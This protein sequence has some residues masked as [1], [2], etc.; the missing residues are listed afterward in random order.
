MD[1]TTQFQASIPPSSP[2]SLSPR[3]RTPPA[4]TTTTT[5]NATPERT[6]PSISL[7]S[8]QPA[9]N[10]DSIDDPR[11]LGNDFDDTALSLPN[12]TAIEEEMQRRLMDVESSF[13]PE[14]STIEVGG[15]AA[16]RDD[17][18]LVGVQTPEESRLDGQD[19]ASRP[20]ALA[21]GFTTPV[22]DR[23]LEPES[24]LMDDSKGGRRDGSIL[25]AI[26]AS[27]VINTSSL[28]TMSSSP[29]AEEAARTVSK[30]LSST[31]RSDNWPPLE[32]P[33]FEF[34]NAEPSSELDLEGSSRQ[35]YPR[36]RSASPLPTLD[37]GDGDGDT[38]NNES[39]SH[40][41]T[42]S[43]SDRRR[44][45]PKFLV[46][47]QSAQRVSMSSVTSAATDA[48]SDANMGVDYALQSGGAM[49]TSSEKR[50][51]AHKQPKAGLSRSISLGSMASVMSALSD[52]IPFEKRVFSGTSEAS[53][54]TLDEEDVSFEPQ[55]L[56]PVDTIKQ[57]DEDFPMTPKARA[58]DSTFPTSTVLAQRVQEVQVPSTFA[59]KF[60]ESAL[61]LSTNN[62]NAQSTASISR[63]KNMT[64]KE[65]SSTIDRLS[66]ENFDLK[67]RIHF[68]NQALNKRSE[69]GIK[70]MISENVELKS[71]KLKLQKEIQSLR[72][73]IRELE[74]QLKD[75]TDQENNT[76]EETGSESDEKRTA[77]EEELTYLRERIETYEVEIERLRADNV[78][79]ESEKRKLA[80]MVKTMGENRSGIAS[81]AG[82]REERDMWK[83][84][85]DAETAAREQ[86]EDENKRLRDEILQ[87]KS[88]ILHD[89]KDHRR[90]RLHSTT[91]HSGSENRH[92]RSSVVASSTTYVELELLK[93]ENAELRREVGAQTSM[94]TSRNRE[95]DRLY[96]EIED[97]KLQRRPD[98]RSVAG[99]S[100]FER[101]ASRAQPRSPSRVSDG[102]RTSRHSE[103]EREALETK[104]GQLRDQVSSL[105]LENQGLRAQVDEYMHELDGLEIEYR[106][107]L[108]KLNESIRHLQIDRDRAR[109]LAENRT[110]DFQ[111]LKE[112]AQEELDVMNE[113]LDVKHDECQR[114][115]AGIQEQQENLAAL[116]AEVRSAN[117][118]ISRLEEDAQNNLHKYKSVQQ[119]LHYANQE[120]EAM[121]KNILEAN[122]KLQ[123]L[124]VQQ[125]SSQNEI[126]FL[127]EEQD[128]DKIKIGDLDSELK[129]AQTSLQHEKERNGELEKSL[130]E[131]RYQREVI[132]SK[133]KQDVQRMINDLNRETSAGKDEIRKL[134]KNLTARE[135]EASTWKERL[136]ELEDSLRTTLGDLNGTRSSLLTSITKIQKELE[137]T[138]LEL[139][140]TRTTLDEK[141]S[142]LRNRDALLESH[143]LETRKL[144]ELLERER[145]AHRADKHSFEQALKSHQQASRTIIQNNSRITDLEGVRNQDRKRFNTLE[146]QYKDQL[147][148]RNAMFLT[149]WKKLSALCGP[150]WAHSNK[151]ING[152][153]PSQEVI[154][155]MLFWPG[156]NRN[157]LL[158][159]K[160]V[161]N[162]ITGFK[163]RIRA[164]DR[165]LTKEY[166]NVEQTLNNRIK[167]LDRLEDMIIQLRSN[168][169]PLPG[170]PVNAELSKLRGENRLLKAELN[171]LQSHSRSR[172]GQTPE[173]AIRGTPPKPPSTITSNARFSVGSEPGQPVDRPRSGRSNSTLSRGSS[174][175]PQPSHYSSSTTLANENYGSS[176]VVSSTA[177]TSVAMSGG[178]TGQSQSNNDQAQDRWIQRLRE[179]ERRLKAEREARLMDRSGARKRLEERDAENEELKAAL[180]RER[181]NRILSSSGGGVAVNDEDDNREYYPSSAEQ[182]SKYD[183]SRD[184]HGRDSNAGQSTTSSRGDVL[185][186]DHGYDKRP[187]GHET[188][189]SEQSDAYY[190]EGD[191]EDDGTGTDEGGLCVEVEV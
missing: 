97:L 62:R 164:V 155:N 66:K 117:E 167:K 190:G 56:S 143:A 55:P 181:Q 158:A 49:P 125:E 37:D 14:P 163:A 106:D 166:Q 21:D 41:T 72:K 110:L 113:E 88:D 154:G 109:Q 74:R 30:V 121:E 152:N 23:T 127:R 105:K 111:D 73:S 175:I 81:E 132:G 168:K 144:A 39:E 35:I 91:S 118:G 85:L 84:M 131:E 57:D 70:E 176:A 24:S 65:Q 17:T 102:T 139:E 61:G 6:S 69:E 159:V 59:R 165:D 63:G 120:L 147:N 184:R 94:L 47:R 95:K 52:D 32:Q 16:G 146:Q 169:R 67:M 11:S 58:S 150:D 183:G 171:L 100:I 115:L 82:A 8:P 43:T 133:E 160:T 33:R 93:Q 156:F 141:E 53:L 174:S 54:H 151:L 129:T 170:T 77:D 34:N 134:K 13:L 157:L 83:D 101:S 104:N 137:S 40:T 19:V 4:R 79:R 119:D 22:I 28:E 108:R 36:D 179:L 42:G 26:G 27:D 187:R 48:T 2:P 186:I 145:Q 50:S 99:D 68:L 142:L 1:D 96:Q 191:D 90:S 148:E 86:T 29:T 60:Q 64:L 15:G 92:N 136:M 180:A 78:T 116:Q 124:T 45:R 18:Y 31:I 112:E 123:R 114:L 25:S 12:R 162:I 153:L 103:H 182:S 122:S 128:A 5:D 140:S 71:D 126:A 138:T 46:S 135:T 172:T 188:A 10:D 75:K 177:A 80:E 178:Q 38:T 107:E 87:L 161:E 189:S 7:L 20:I 98:G 173:R 44:K 9:N 185:V 3:Q 76:K 149:L 130:A 51:Q 89:S